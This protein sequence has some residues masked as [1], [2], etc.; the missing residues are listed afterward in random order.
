MPAKLISSI[1]MIYVAFAIRGDQRPGEPQN[2]IARRFAPTGTDSYI[3][4]NAA[5]E[6]FTITSLSSFITGAELRDALPDGA[7]AAKNRL[8]DGDAVVIAFFFPYSD[9]ITRTKLAD[10]E[11]TFRGL[12]PTCAEPSIRCALFFHTSRSSGGRVPSSTG[13]ASI[14]AIPQFVGDSDLL[15][16]DIARAGDEPWPVKLDNNVI[17]LIF[18]KTHALRVMMVLRGAT[19]DN[20]TLPLLGMLLSYEP[21]LCSDCGATATHSTPPAERRARETPTK[22]AP[23]AKK[24]RTPRQTTP[25]LQPAGSYLLQSR[26]RGLASITGLLNLHKSTPVLAYVWGTWCGPCRE[27]WPSLQRLHTAFSANT[28]F[29]GFA[30]EYSST[31]LDSVERYLSDIHRTAPFVSAA[32]TYVVP[33][34]EQLDDPNG[35]GVPPLIDELRGVPPP[36][37]TLFTR[38][39][40]VALSLRGKIANHDNFQTLLCGLDAVRRRD[41]SET[42]EAL[43]TCKDIHDI[44]AATWGTQDNCAHRRM[45]K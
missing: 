21:Q 31:S 36:A 37:F 16:R 44:P 13:I 2:T 18:D 41:Q 29:I 9:S 40:R 34:L 45:T 8:R 19:A 35:K 42:D 33:G 30:F 20:A 3:Y 32:D 23:R 28:H 24:A 5:A 11:D 10:Y 43:C 22:P 27:D 17:A 4:R 12:A 7:I 14:P 15:L 38:T 1:A 6:R 39:G 25:P 26:Q